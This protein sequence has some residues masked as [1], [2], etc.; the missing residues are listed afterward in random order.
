MEQVASML[1]NHV[2]AIQVQQHSV[3]VSEEGMAFKNALN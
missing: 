2:Q 1:M 3:K